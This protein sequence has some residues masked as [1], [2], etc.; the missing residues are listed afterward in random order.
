MLCGVIIGDNL[1]GY[2]YL[3]RKKKKSVEETSRAECSKYARS[4]F[5]DNSQRQGILPTCT[6]SCMEPSV[7]AGSPRFACGLVCTKDSGNLHD[8]STDE[9]TVNMFVLG[10]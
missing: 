2:S 6:R 8:F 10:F 3:K 1:L 4:L 7:G 5:L 9:P